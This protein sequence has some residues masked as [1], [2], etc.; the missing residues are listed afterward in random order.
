MCFDQYSSLGFAAIGFFSSWWIYS[1][2][3]NFELAK[4]VF[5]FFTM[6]FLQFLQYFVIAPSLDS[7]ICNEFINQ[8]LTI[9]GFL[10]IC[11]QPYFCHVINASLV[12]RPR[13]AGRGPPAARA[14]LF[15]GD[16]A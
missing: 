16:N 1:R 6:E 8:F 12:R 2:T 7:P 14:R 5:F 15:G 11:L 4:G 3:E 10:H 9:L 13:A